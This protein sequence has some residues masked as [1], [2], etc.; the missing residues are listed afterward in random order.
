[1]RPQVYK[2]STKGLAADSGLE[3]TDRMIFT[4]AKSAICYDITTG[5][6]I[7]PFLLKSKDSYVTLVDETEK[8]PPLKLTPIYWRMY[9]A[10]EKVKAELRILAGDYN[11]EIIEK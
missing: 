10:N 3:S 7:E 8:Q 4:G 9:S 2:A 11:I 6:V 5:E 1:M